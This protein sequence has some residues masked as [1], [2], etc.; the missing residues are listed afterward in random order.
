M[1]KV[2][3][4]FHEILPPGTFL[5]SMKE[6]ANWY[7][8]NIEKFGVRRHECNAEP[9]LH[10]IVLKVFDNPFSQ[11]SID[12]WMTEDKVPLADFERVQERLELMIQE[13]VVTEFPTIA[14]R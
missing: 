9:L 6:A 12:N 11:K 4:D 8:K 14:Y 1:A 2:K 10:E 13:R 7:I 3:R 5:I